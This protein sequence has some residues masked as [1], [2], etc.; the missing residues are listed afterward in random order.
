MLRGTLWL[1]TLSPRAR[2][3]L[4]FGGYLI[5]R[6]TGLML[7]WL[8]AIWM[9]WVAG[10]FFN[11]LLRLDRFGR[12][13]LSREQIVESNWVGAMLVTAVLSLVAYFI[14]RRDPLLVAGIVFGLL[15]VPVAGVFRIAESWQRKA[16]LAYVGLMVMLGVP[17]IFIM[18]FSDEVATGLRG[19]PFWFFLILALLSGL[20]A[21]A[22][23]VR[24]A[25][26]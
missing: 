5:T 25:K 11:L 4:Y 10:P 24:A 22:L 1:S 16:M 13:A 9:T 21:N 15:P 17:S 12:L 6:V 18:S 3:W 8:V 23:A 19:V 7:L 14:T 26:R 20:I 2:T